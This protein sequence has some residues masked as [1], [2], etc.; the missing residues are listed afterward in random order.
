MEHLFNIHLYLQKTYYVASIVLHAGD[1]SKSESCDTWSS[2]SHFEKQ[3][4]NIWKIFLKHLIVIVM[5]AGGERQ[6]YW[7]TCGETK[8][9]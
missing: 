6:Q 1:E 5:S 7:E 3:L 9:L 8:Y 2:G 4:L